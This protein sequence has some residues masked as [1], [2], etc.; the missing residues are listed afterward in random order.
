MREQIS[1]FLSLIDEK[2]QIIIDTLKMLDSDTVDTNTITGVKKQ[3]N[4]LLDKIMQF[5]NKAMVGLAEEEE[6][7][8]YSTRP[9]SININ[10]QALVDASVAKPAE[11]I[12]EEGDYEESSDSEAD[13]ETLSK[14]GASRLGKGPKNHSKIGR[15]HV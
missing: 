1:E 14:G 3:L 15:A 8:K 4:S 10:V 9:S 11:A 2:K 6:L 12:N 13:G 7:V 5:K